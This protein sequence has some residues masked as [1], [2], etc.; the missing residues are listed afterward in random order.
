MWF[1]GR[2]TAQCWSVRRVVLRL[3]DVLAIC[4]QVQRDSACMHD[5]LRRAVHL[6]VVVVVVLPARCCL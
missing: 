3:L 1:S 4:G 6:L 2:I 5:M